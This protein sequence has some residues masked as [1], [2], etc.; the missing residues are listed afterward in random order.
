[1]LQIR[2]KP[3]ELHHGM[4]T[5][6]PGY[7]APGCRSAPWQNLGIFSIQLPHAVPLDP[8]L[9]EILLKLFKILPPSDP[10]LDLPKHVLSSLSMLNDIAASNNPY[11]WFGLAPVLSLNNIQTLLDNNHL[12]KQYQGFSIISTTSHS[13]MGQYSYR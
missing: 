12:I 5:K 6:K 11:P 10:I 3:N 8:P 2:R 9:L 7:Y 13:V 1:M 4:T